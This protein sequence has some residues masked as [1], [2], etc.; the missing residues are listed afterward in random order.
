VVDLTLRSAPDFER[1]VTPVF[2]FNPGPENPDALL[3]FRPRPATVHGPADLC[4]AAI[5]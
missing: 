3:L 1:D 4:Q 5:A 2:R